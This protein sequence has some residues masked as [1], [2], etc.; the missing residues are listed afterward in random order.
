[1][2][3]ISATINVP[4]IWVLA[5]I[6]CLLLL[7]VVSVVLMIVAWQRKRQ[8]EYFAADAKIIS[9]IDGQNKP[10][11]INLPIRHDFIQFLTEIFPLAQKRKEKLA[12]LLLDLDN[13]KDINDALGIDAGDVLLKQVANRIVEQV[14]NDSHIISHFGGGEFA[15]LLGFYEE[16]TAYVA[17]KAEKL[18]FAI[19]ENF[20]IGQHDL[21]ISASIG[22]GIFPDHTVVPE[23][24]LRYA[25]M[26]R[27]NAKHKSKNTYSFY[28]DGMSKQTLDR[29]LIYA[30]LR[31]ALDNDELLLH[32][33]PKISAIT[34]KVIGA[35]ALVRWEHPSRGQISPEIFIPVAEN[36]GMIIPMGKWILRTACLALKQ[37]HAEG[38][39]DLTMA[40]NLSPY[41]FNHGDIAGSIAGIL[42]ETGIA[43]AALEL[44]LTESMVMGNAEKSLLMLRV[45]KAMGIKIAIDDFGTGY[46]SLSHLHNFPIDT[47]KIDKSFIRNMLLE[48]ESVTIVATIISMAKQLGLEVVAEGVEQQEEVDLLLK[49]GCNYFQ[50]YFYSQPV[51]IEQLIEFIKQHN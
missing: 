33:Q 25:D 6:S 46:S 29:T 18:L 31:K 41:Q 40:V 1:M 23:N 13:F 9:N 38:F 34:N 30:D 19:N 2:D 37:L 21:L 49:E 15:I 48:A 14:A 8:L 11:L 16:S 20:H 26:A 7:I 45:L 35:E 5:F 32:Y 51:P 36:S 39:T 44:E 4:T 47:L 27:Y 12:L 24:L 50:G 3:S 22:I 17:D 28:N 10:A 42:W 43:P